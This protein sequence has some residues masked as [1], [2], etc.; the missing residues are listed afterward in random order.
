MQAPM[1]AGP[2]VTKMEP[3]DCVAEWSGTSL[4]VRGVGDAAAFREP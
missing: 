1:A 2:E 3:A 4:R